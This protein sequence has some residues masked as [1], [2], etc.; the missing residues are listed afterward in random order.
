MADD[1]GH[2]VTFE[3]ADA[4]SSTTFP[5]QAGSLRKGGHIVIKGRPCKVVEVST[6]K[7][8][9]HGHAKC[10]FVGIDLFTGK[11][12]EELV[13]SSHN[14]ESPFVTRTEYTLTDISD[15]DFVCLM[16]ESGETR[17]DLTLP[18]K[19]DDDK[20]LSEDIRAAFDAGDK[21]VVVTVMGA[22]KEES[23]IAFK[24]VSD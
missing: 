23:I 10:H 18:E 20:K 19:T 12:M 14:C 4:G 24:T 16:T 8:G 9:K 17:E 11:K 22:M 1:H 2:D 13:P 21:A 5:V 15:D 3:S 7:T 6:S